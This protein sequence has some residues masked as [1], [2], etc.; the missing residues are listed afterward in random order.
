MQPLL[1]PCA[2]RPHLSSLELFLAGTVHLLFVA[3]Y[4]LVWW[5]AAAA[6]L[7]WHM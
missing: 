3:F 1:K 5:V 7:A 2:L 4:L 6:V